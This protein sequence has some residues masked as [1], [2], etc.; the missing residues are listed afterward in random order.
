[1]T[2]RVDMSDF[3]KKF[4]T[5]MNRTVPEA[6]EYGMK[7][8]AA[9]IL[10]DVAS[11]EPTAPLMTGRLRG[12]GSAFYQNKLVG[13]SP[14]HGTG[15]PLLTIADS[16]DSRQKKLTI[17]YNTPYARL[18]HEMVP[19]NWFLRRPTPFK[20]PTAGIKF[21]E[22]KLLRNRFIYMNLLGNAMSR[23]MSQ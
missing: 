1:M 16:V 20:E 4:T 5:M 12:S 10:I 6:I 18:W 11:E 17:I 9:E 19:A 21:L 14:N 3:N 2:L 15:T 7:E 13:L 23:R 22:L 8:V